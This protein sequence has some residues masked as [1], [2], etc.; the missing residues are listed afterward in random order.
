MGSIAQQLIV[1]KQNKEF[2]QR[3]Y[4]FD[5]AMEILKNAA[6]DPTIHDQATV[7]QAYK[8]ID[9]L[10]KHDEKH[11]SAFKHA[12]LR[13]VPQLQPDFPAQPPNG[14][15]M[16]SG[17]SAAPQAA[18]VPPPPS[19]DPGL[20]APQMSPPPGGAS[21]MPPLPGSSE[22]QPGNGALPA[23]PSDTTAPNPLPGIRSA[24]SGG[25]ST[26]GVGNNPQILRN[27]PTGYHMND[28]MQRV[29]AGAPA[30]TAG[31][32]VEQQI[33]QRM[34]AFL[35]TPKE[36]GG[37]G[38]NQVQAADYL[39]KHQVQYEPTTKLGEGDV[40]ANNTTGDVI[41]AGA[42]KITTIAP[43]GMGQ[44]VDPAMRLTNQAAGV[45]PPPG[46]GV[47]EIAGP[48]LPL[49]RAM[50]GAKR[51]YIVSQQKDNP[52]YVWSDADLPKAIAL[53]KEMS[54][55]PTE[56]IM[57]EATLANLAEM[58]ANR[59][60]NE[61]NLA[62]HMQEFRQTKGPEA[63][64]AMADQIYSNPETVKK[65]T[66]DVYNLVAQRYQQKYNLPMPRELPSPDQQKEDASKLTLNHIAGMRELLQNP[67]IQKR[68]GAFRGRVGDL[69]QILGDTAGLSDA[70]KQA[71]QAFRTR[72]PYLFSQEARSV[73]GGRPP[74]KFME[75]LKAA[76]P[77]MKMGLPFFM[78]ALD[79][80]EAMG[81]LN[82]LTA[83]QI[84]N[85]GKVRPEIQQQYGM[86]TPPRAAPPPGKIE[87]KRK[88][89]GRMGFMDEHDFNPSLYDKV[90]AR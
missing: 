53:E 66:G 48:P 40:L 65:L 47:R 8:D 74:Q 4:K 71:I 79:S 76:S 39:N 46:N 62:L 29:Q 32:Q 58:R 51:A 78:G 44:L 63:I 69:E 59:K 54:M 64:D 37:G 14:G 41:A 73:L 12:V 77:S 31:A 36:Q 35:T 81:K 67:V 34:F 57:K 10:T 28:A 61:A 90:N 49:P 89:D 50:E 82:V 25:F 70:D 22:G 16:S 30:R 83:E 42:P 27:G 56:R 45:P 5:A 55:S 87:V 9:T 88:S 43:G 52:S 11:N 26:L 60:L 84:R 18:M 86:P 1:G 13:G 6:K 15:A 7:N 19:M 75:D 2:E 68:M 33:T 80:M 72:I 24:P 38:L 20:N 85:G 21:P 23:V 17:G 3:K